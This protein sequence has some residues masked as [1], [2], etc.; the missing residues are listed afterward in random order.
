MLRLIA[1]TLITVAAA[2]AGEVSTI[3]EI[4][5]ATGA[6]AA[7]LLAGAVLVLRTRRRK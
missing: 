2:T 6:S 3:P 4:D 7:A 5:P 1:L